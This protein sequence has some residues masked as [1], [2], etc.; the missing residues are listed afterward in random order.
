M[1]K[2]KKH[3]NPHVGCVPCNAT[4]SKNPVL[5]ALIRA[6]QEREARA[7]CSLDG[8][9]QSCDACQGE[10]VTTRMDGKRLDEIV[11]Y[12]RFHLEDLGGSWFLDLG[13][14]KLNL[15][16]TKAVAVDGDLHAGTVTRAGR[17][18]ACGKRAMTEA[19]RAVVEAAMEWNA[20]R[21]DWR[22]AQSVQFALEAACAAM[23]KERA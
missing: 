5:P 17:E 13:G 3:T 10:Y 11:G 12:G 4:P 8:E 16:S 1:S 15:T 22:A 6:M 7:S 2:R 9:T 20:K 19:E 18:H 21:R 23:R 14:L